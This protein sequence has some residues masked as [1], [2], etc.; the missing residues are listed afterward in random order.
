VAQYTGLGTFVADR[1]IPMLALGEG[2]DFRDLYAVTGLSNVLSHLTTAPAAPAIL[3]PLASSIATETGWS[4]ETIAMVQVV[5]IST[6][7]LPY[8]A[9]PL[10][11]AMALADIPMGALFRVCLWLAAAVAVIGMPLTY[12]WWSYLGMFG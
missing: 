10:I 5:G 12:L 3:A 1:L 9:P 7:I 8:Q 4:L 6:P 11:I 2:S